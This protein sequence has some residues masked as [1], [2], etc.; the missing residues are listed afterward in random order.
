[1]NFNLGGLRLAHLQGRAARHRSFAGRYR[2]FVKRT[3]AQ[4]AN[5]ILALLVVIQAQCLFSLPAALASDTL[6]VA[7][8]KDVGVGGSFDSLMD[9]LKAQ[10]NIRAIVL[11]GNDISNGALR[12]FHILIVP[13]GSG[14]KEAGSLGPQGQEEIKRFISNGGSFIGI[15]AGCYLASSST[16]FLGLLPMG[17]RDRK[18]WFRGKAVIPI[19]YTPAGEELFGLNN[20]AYEI[21]YHNGPILDSRPL[22][23]NPQ[24]G[25]SVMPL[26]FYRGEIV[27]RGGEPGVMNGAPAMVLSRYGR[28]FVLGISPHP[29]RTPPLYKTI[30]N[31]LY[32]LSRH[33]VAGAS[34][35]GAASPISSFFDGASVD[36]ASGM[37]GSLAR[38]SIDNAAP[39]AVPRQLSPQSFASSEQAAT[40]IAQRALDLARKIFL[41]AD[42]VRY[43]HNHVPATDQISRDGSG[44][45]ARTD[46]SGFVS[47]VV[48][49]VSPQHYRIVRDRQ[50]SADYPQ[51]KTWARFF[52]T[53]PVDQ[54]LDGWIQVPRYDQLR[55]GDLIAWTK[56]RKAP[57]HAGSGNTG[58]VMIVAAQPGQPQREVLDG[59]PVTYVSVPVIDSS[60][61]YHFPPERLPPNAHQDHR[62]GLGLGNVRIILST[63]GDAI[64]YWEGTYWGEGQ[65]PVEGPKLSSEVRFARMVS[66][67]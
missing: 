35:P 52:S 46:C 59:Q 63:A 44:F 29:E 2:S 50:P 47:Y 10:P 30:P 62:N 42:V 51:A 43:V 14:K 32:W 67:Q 15:C 66:M 38:R 1:M 3:I 53:L 37:S 23:E 28:G 26:A 22:A 56:A 7:V 57:D 18:H 45:V 55:A 4:I 5:C 40:P 39:A 16:D 27:G 36:R 64:G 54:P 17:I 21:V 11:D 25:S 49:S 12:R 19:E 6:E 58:H 60:S 9:V 13:G 41:L 48:R 31:A 33:S 20:P 34:E 65:K 24:L 8:Y 61:V